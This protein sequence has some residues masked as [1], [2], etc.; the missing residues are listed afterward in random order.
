[1]LR[2]ILGKAGAGKTAAVIEELRQAVERR[3][4][5]NLLLVP[6]QYSHEAERELCLKCGDSLSLYAEVFSFSGL[7]R[8]I[9]QQQGGGAAS[10]LDKGGRLLCMAL[11]LRAVGPR[12]RSY[13]AAQRNA[14]L[15]AMLL[16]AVD[17]MKAARVTAEM[18][19]GAAESCG[20]GLGD[21]LRDLAL[22]YGAY[23]AV[24]ARGHADP[25]DRLGILA[26]QIPES[27]LGPDT[28]VYV[29]GFVDFTAQE[30][31]VLS[32][33]LHKG[34]QMTVCMT[35]DDLRSSNEIYGLSRIAARRLLAE[36]KEL[37]TEIAVEHMEGDGKDE[38]LRFFADKL[39]SY[40]PEH[41]ERDTAA[42]RLHSAETVTA[43]CEFAAGRAL[44]LVRDGGCRWRDI[45]LAIRGFEDYRGTLES[46]FRHYGVPLFAARRSELLS[47]PLPALIAMSYEIVD[48]G[49]D[50]DDVISYMRTGLAGLDPTACDTL[51]DYI[52]KWQL[53]GSA[54]ERPG[55]WRQ[56]PAGYGAEYDEAAEERLRQ[57][58]KNF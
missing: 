40:S 36:A 26:G 58:A 4:G 44:E 10:F 14:E 28:H 24:V 7:A 37:G 29:D 15:Q 38:A 21:K 19:E 39:F 20:D 55:D 32:A 33:L 57:S 50:V 12:L 41:Y 34:V 46:V 47:K 27:S 18:L 16:R 5:G 43:E 35:V 17:E 31:A 51:A 9:M 53:R 11:A 2:L 54:W 56:H 1:M 25:M 3:Q 30:R 42:V 49:W 23:D 8:R 52:F 22:I 48:G 13:P 6:E 45:A